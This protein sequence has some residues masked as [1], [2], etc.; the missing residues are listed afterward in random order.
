MT[1]QDTMIK[2]AS[3][4]SYPTGSNSMVT[5]GQSRLKSH[6]LGTKKLKVGRERHPMPMLLLKHQVRG[7]FQTLHATSS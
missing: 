2:W 3:Y 6:T 7:R 1:W 5:P 4:G